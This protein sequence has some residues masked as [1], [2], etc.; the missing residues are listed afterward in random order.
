MLRKYALI[1]LFTLIST[2]VFAATFVSVA[3]V[4]DPRGTVWLYEFNVKS[5]ALAVSAPLSI[6]EYACWKKTKG[7]TLPVSDKPW[8]CSQTEADARTVAQKEADA[9]EARIVAE[10]K[11]TTSMEAYRLKSIVVNKLTPP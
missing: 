1:V 5:S 6:T 7:Q 8:K 11:S 2:H 4:P 9:F 3:E 10:G